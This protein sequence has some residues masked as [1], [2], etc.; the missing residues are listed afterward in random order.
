MEPRKVKKKR[1]RLTQLRNSCRLYRS[2]LVEIPVGSTG[3][4]C[5]NTYNFFQ[6]C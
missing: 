6:A 1:R 3:P 2:N 5:W 4:T